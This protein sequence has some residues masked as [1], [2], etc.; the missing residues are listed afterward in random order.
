MP[1]EIHKPCAILPKAVRRGIQETVVIILD[2][3]GHKNRIISADIYV[4]NLNRM[5]VK[6]FADAA[7]N[8]KH[9]P[10]TTT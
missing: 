5:Y 10:I 1:I 2:T 7:S 6:I 8:L 4:L 3:L 9:F